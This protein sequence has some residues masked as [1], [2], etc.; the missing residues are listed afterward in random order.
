M[1]EIYE[2]SAE[3]IRDLIN[4]DF[5]LFKEMWDSDQA[6][7]EDLRFYETEDG[8]DVIVKGGIEGIEDDSY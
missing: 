5:D 2:M 6:S 3:E 4:T 7:D 1:K 8:F